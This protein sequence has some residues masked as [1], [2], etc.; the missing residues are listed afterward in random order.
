MQCQG[1]TP[2]CA[3]KSVSAGRSPALVRDH[4]RVCGEKLRHR[5]GRR[6]HVGSPPR[7]RGKVNMPLFWSLATGITPACAG[8]SCLTALAVFLC[9]DHPRVCGEKN[10]S[11]LLP[12]SLLGSPPRV[13]GKAPGQRDP[14]QCP[15]ITPACA[16]KRSKSNSERLMIRDHPRVCGEK[17]KLRQRNTQVRGSPP[18]VRGKVEDEII[19]I[20]D[21]RITPAHAGKRASASPAPSVPWDHPRACGEK[22]C[23]DLALSV[24][25]GS[26]PRMRG[27]VPVWRCLWLVAWDHPRACGEKW[28]TRR[29]KDAE[30][31][32]PP[33]MRGKEATSP[34]S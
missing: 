31:G 29:F 34:H 7:V 4:P 6:Q 14:C 23:W 30:T 3:G 33:R 13:R 15:G 18:R 20:Q 28:L 2:A 10:Q 25:E 22:D 1:I 24:V 11:V 16:G 8:K 19:N 21:E 27:K 32:S 12:P 26:P 5:K 9:R 17:E